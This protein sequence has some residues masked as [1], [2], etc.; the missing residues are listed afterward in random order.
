MVLGAQGQA[1][2]PE[3]FRSS[4]FWPKKSSSKY[5]YIYREREGEGRERERVA[6]I[7]VVPWLLGLQ[8]QYP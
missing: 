7:Q 8:C 2:I 5:I 3:G 6:V 1:R 4:G